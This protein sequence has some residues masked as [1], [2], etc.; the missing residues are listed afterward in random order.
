MTSCLPPGVIGRG[1]PNGAAR[2]V[3]VLS[4]IFLGFSVSDQI[5]VRGA[6]TKMAYGLWREAAPADGSSQ[7]T[8]SI[9]PQFEERL[10]TILSQEQLKNYRSTSGMSPTGSSSWTE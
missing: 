7:T 1:F 5:E 6:I 4:V 3:L 8:K 9:R 2:L 10:E